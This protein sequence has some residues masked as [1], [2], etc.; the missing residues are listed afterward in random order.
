MLKLHITHTTPNQ[1]RTLRSQIVGIVYQWIKIFIQAFMLMF[2]L[3]CEC[4]FCLLS[5]V[6]SSS[7]F[8]RCCFDS[9]FLP[10]FIHTCILHT[11]DRYVIIHI[12]REAEGVNKQVDAIV[13]EASHPM[14]ALQFSDVHCVH[15][16]VTEIRPS[17]HWVFMIL[18][19]TSAYCLFVCLFNLLYWLHL[20]LFDCLKKIEIISCHY[21]I[22]QCSA[23]TTT[24]V[25][26]DGAQPECQHTKFAIHT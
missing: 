16:I 9:T 14:S 17:D 1:I 26:N 25:R 7:A 6:L 2:F 22:K 24:I 11:C 13:L 12:E 5:I 20:L 19:S 21:I 18:Y 10:H 23:A 8:F 15:C 4:S 3:F